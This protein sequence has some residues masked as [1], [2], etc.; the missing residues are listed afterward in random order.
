MKED[1][2]TTTDEAYD[3]GKHAD[4]EEADENFIVIKADKEVDRCCF[5]FLYLLRVMFF[6]RYGLGVLV[7]SSYVSSDQGINMDR[8]TM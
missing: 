4:G 2:K 5:P 7:V 6:L 8:G 1:L 3:D